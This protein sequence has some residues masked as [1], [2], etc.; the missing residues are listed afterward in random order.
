[1]LRK[2]VKVSNRMSLMQYALLLAGGLLFVLYILYEWGNTDRFENMMGGFFIGTWL[3]AIFYFGK[4]RQTDHKNDID[5]IQFS[6]TQLIISYLQDKPVIFAYSDIQCCKF[7]LNV[8]QLADWTACVSRT[9]LT[10]TIVFADG[11]VYQ[12]IQKINDGF[13]RKSYACAIDALKCKRCFPKLNLEVSATGHYGIA[14]K[15]IE[16]YRLFEKRYMTTSEKVLTVLLF[17]LGL[18]SLFVIYDMFIN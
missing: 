12:K 18:V 16:H 13:F 3:S 5:K 9:D 14:L 2:V 8:S 4:C 10:F 1:M 6:D 11:N 15:K 7:F 17:F